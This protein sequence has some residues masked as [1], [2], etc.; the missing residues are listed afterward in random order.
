MIII[1][2]QKKKI[3]TILEF[4]EQLS[5]SWQ[6]WIFLGKRFK[7]LID[8]NNPKYHKFYNDIFP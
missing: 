2:N 8:F 5:L 4:A 3:A 6:K 7:Y 1:I